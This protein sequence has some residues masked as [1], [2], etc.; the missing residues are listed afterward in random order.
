MR[1]TSTLLLPVVV[2][3]ERYARPMR[4][5]QTRSAR[6]ARPEPPAPS[7]EPIVGAIRP[8]V[9]QRRVLEPGELDVGE[10]IRR[11]IE[12]R[13]GPTSGPTFWR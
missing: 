12:A 5:R 9:Q 13:R 2:A 3:N 10:R 11:S 4:I 6:R 8:G 1:A 7:P